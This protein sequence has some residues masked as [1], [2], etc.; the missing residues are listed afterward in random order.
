MLKFTITNIPTTTRVCRTHKSDAMT[1]ALHALPIGD[2]LEKN[3]NIE[4]Q[5]D[6]R[7]TKHFNHV[8]DPAQFAHNMSDG[9]S[10]I[11]I[12]E[13]GL[14]T[15]CNLGVFALYSKYPKS[16]ITW[17]AQ[18]DV[19]DKKK[20]EALKSTEEAREAKQWCKDGS[21]LRPRVMGTHQQVLFNL[22]PYMIFLRIGCLE[23]KITLIIQ[24]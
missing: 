2:R 9:E 16:I 18:Q 24:I 7:H 5:N 6:T 23:P 20:R 17:L 22:S 12:D 19:K 10:I 21:D 14:A 13:E 4:S 11:T 1:T 3:A 15:L 8:L